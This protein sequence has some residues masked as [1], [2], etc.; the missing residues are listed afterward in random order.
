MTFNPTSP[1]TPTPVTVLFVHEGIIVGVACP[2]PSQCTAA[3]GFGRVATFNPISPGSPT[4]ITVDSDGLNGLACP[5][6]SQCTAVDGLGREVTFNP[7]SPGTPTPTTI[8]DGYSLGPVACPSADQCTVVTDGYQLT[9]FSKVATT[10]TVRCSPSVLAPGDATVCTATVTQT[11]SGGRATPTG[12]VS[13]SNSGTGGFPGSPCTLS[14]S[15]ASAS[16]AVFFTSFAR[17]GQGITASYGGDDSHSAS[18]GGT[19][20]LVALPPSTNGCVVHGHG[21]ITAANGDQASFRLLVAASP[22]RGAA[23]YR[24]WGP[25]D[26]MRLG[27]TSVDGADLQHRCQH[28]PARSEARA[29][30]VAARSSTA[31]T[32]G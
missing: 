2:S 7:V 20:L 3:D 5:S 25:A 12:K 9:G 15:G 1:G 23:F 24:D 6:T 13:F 8:F 4:P 26:A 14:G 21:R 10:T 19:F 18:S 32:F 11:P 16:C 29:S 28:G 31:S 27:S 17:G 22:P 30:A